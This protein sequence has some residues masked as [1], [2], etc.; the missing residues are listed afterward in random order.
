[1][2]IPI[3]IGNTVTFIASA[4]ITEGAACVNN[5]EGYVI[6]GENE[7]DTNFVGYAITSA[8]AG[9]AVSLALPG[10]IVQGVCGTTGISIGNYLMLH[11]ASGRVQPIGALS[12]SAYNCVG[13]ALEA[14][15]TAGDKISIL[16][17]NFRDRA[18][19]Q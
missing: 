16:V 13:Q 11:G 17:L 9:D 19:V 12:G 2:A 7:N 4:T 14:G 6:M 5:T 8:S 18:E 1:M 10:S 3:R 15:D